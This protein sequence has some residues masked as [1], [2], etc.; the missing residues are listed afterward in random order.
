MSESNENSK[1]N[2]RDPGFLGEM[3]NKLRLAYYLLRDPEVPFYLKL[4]PFS[5]I[6]YFLF[7]F[8]GVVNP[9]LLTPVD[10][11]ALIVVAV[12]TFL[13][14][15]PPHIVE[16]YEAKMEGRSV[17]AEN[18]TNA[19]VVEGEFQ[20]VDAG[21]EIDPLEQIIILNPDKVNGYQ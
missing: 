21:A 12:T 18:T 9:L 5:S 4:I 11:I 3:F 6:A 15:A 19:S 13:Q 16:K 2:W 8:E 20:A 1:M 10:D 17:S 14:M 7:P